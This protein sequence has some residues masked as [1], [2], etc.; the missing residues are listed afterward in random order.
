MHCCDCVKEKK[1][2]RAERS[3]LAQNA[4]LYQINRVVSRDI[5]NV[6]WILFRQVLIY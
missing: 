2:E 4:K 5:K 6:V 3:N 1:K